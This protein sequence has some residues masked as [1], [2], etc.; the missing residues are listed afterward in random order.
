MSPRRRRQARRA[1]R[2]GTT[3]QAAGAEAAS[4]QPTRYRMREKLLT[5]GNDFVIETGA[6]VPAYRVDGKAVRV[7]NTIQIRDANGL[8]VY[9]VQELKVRLKD[10]MIIQAGNRTVAR[11]LKALVTPFRDRFDV[12]VPG[13]Q[14]L[15]VQ[16]NVVDHE[17]TITRGSTLVA[18]VSRRWFRVRDTY[19]VEVMP[20]E[21]DA[22]ILAIAAAIDTIT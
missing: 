12:E 19:G 3:P 7:R 9:R 21:D 17:Y 5:I 15:H 18:T 22:L 6:G 4:P 10:T 16:G 2:R 8:P 20:G 1:K 14:S 13:G 11:L